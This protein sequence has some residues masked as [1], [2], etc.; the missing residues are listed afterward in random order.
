MTFLPIVERELR[1]A[2]RSRGTY[3][4]RMATALV[5]LLIGGGFLIAGL[6]MRA[7][8]ASPGVAA[9]DDMFYALSWYLFLI[10]LLAGLFLAA[11]CLS[12]ERREGTL[13]FLFL[14]DLRGYDIVLG[15]LLAVSLKAFY[16]LLSVFPILGLSLML[17]GITGGEF[18]RICL[19]L[20]N[21]LWFSI[22]T[23]LW[24]SSR[25]ELSHRATIQTFLLLILLAVVLPG[26]SAVFSDSAWLSSICSVSPFEPFYFAQAAN[27]LRQAG[28]FW[29]SLVVS[30]LAGWLFVGLAS[31][32]LP[33]FLEAPP[34]RQTAGSWR[35][36][37]TGDL[38]LGGIKRRPE[39]LDINP[40]LWLM[41]DS[42]GLRWLIWGLSGVGSVLVL[43]CAAFGDFGENG[44]IAASYA[45]RPFYFLLQVL[46]AIQACR[47]FSEAR[48]TGTLEILGATP[49]ADKTI[50][51]G[52]WLFLKRQFVWPVVVLMSAEILSAG[53]SVCLGR[54]HENVGG[55]VFS[56]LWISALP[57][58]TAI[59]DFFA[60]GWFGIWLSLTGKKPQSAAGLTILFVILLPSFVCVPTLLTN[61]VFILVC[62]S[63]LA[64]NFRHLASAR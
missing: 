25:S 23:A 47:F 24:V 27:Y 50:Y 2:A 32:R 53:V 49:L 46:F 19:A 60:I 43:A 16:G 30:N 59:V 42:R 48:R 14:T 21:A 62:K 57:I 63:K 38:S 26:C 35:G 39:L 31:W 6:L 8:G 15:K 51:A 61:V 10:C 52:L 41:E 22:T 17:G 13:G 54:S 29:T 64:R 12:V 11:D 45:A 58:A 44:L 40:V 4:I 18:A 5:A 20:A 36:L 28:G 55:M 37:L 3:Y 33:R 34:A 56:F 1:V 7:A 9:G